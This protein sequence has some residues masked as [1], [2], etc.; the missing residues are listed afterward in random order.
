MPTGYGPSQLQ[1]AY[2]L[3]TPSSVNGS[4]QTVAI[5]DAFDDPTAESD[6]AV[7][8]AQFGLPACTVANGCFSKV[9]QSG[10]A[11]PLPPTAPSD[12]MLE[13]SLDVDMVSAICP[14]CHILLVDAQAPSIE[15]MGAG[16]NA[17]VALGAKF[18]SLSFT[19]NESALDPGYDA[20][21]FHHPGVVIT[22][23]S[24]DS[25]PRSAYPAAS[26]DVTAVGGTTLNPAPNARGW[27]ESAWSS[28]GSIC[29][30]FS[31]KPRW[32]ADTGCRNRSV[33]DV[34][35]I[36]DGPSGVAVYDGGWGGAAG[37]SV[38][39]P[40]IAS[41]YALAG[42]P[43]PGS[44]PAYYPYAH[45]ASLYDVTSGST[46]SSCA[47]T[48]LCTAEAGYDGPTGLGTPNGIAAFAPGLGDMINVVYPGNRT[49]IVGTSG[50]LAIAA[51]DSA[52]LPVTFSA[53]GLPPGMSLNSANGVITGNPTTLGTYY[54]D[55]TATDTAGATGSTMYTWTIVVPGRVVVTNPGSQGGVTGSL[56]TLQVNASVQRTC[57]P[58][59]TYAATSLPAGLTI[60]P[61]NGLISGTPTT[62]AMSI[63]TVVARAS[64]GITGSATFTW[65]IGSP[66]T[67][68]TVRVVNPHDRAATVGT[69]VGI[70]LPA[71][72]SDPTQTLSYELGGDLP[73]GL[74]L[75]PATGLIS[76]VPT[77]AGSF[78]IN[79]GATDSTG[80]LDIAAF[81]LTISANTVTVTSPGNL[82]GT[83]GTAVSV[84]VAATDSDLSEALSY[85]ATGLP[86]G[87]FIN[88]RTGML[89]QGPASAGTYNVTVTATDMT[90]ATGSASFT[91]T[92]SPQ[93]PD[94]VL[95]AFPGNPGGDV[96]GTAM[97]LQLSGTYTLPVTY[98]A[99]G[100]PPGITISPG[101]LLSGTPTTAGSYQVTVTATDPLGTTGSIIL[102]WG[103]G[104]RGGNIIQ[105]PTPGVQGGPVG[106]LVSLPVNASDSDPAQPL[107]FTANLPPGLWINP[108]TGLISGAPAAPGVYTIDVNVTD[109]TAA[110]ADMTFTWTIGAPGIGNTVIVAQPRNQST[111]A[112]SGT[113][114]QVQAGDTDP[115][116]VLG[117]S[118]AGLPAGMSIDPASGLIS[119]PP[120]TSGTYT[121]TVSVSD[122]AAASGSATFTWTVT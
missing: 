90:G 22:A 84:P 2:N 109:T 64:S 100:L 104:V 29:S 81:L 92:V 60:N 87:V 69:E 15:N 46:A 21:F 89:W 106:T 65:T 107:S 28:A 93:P 102:T 8:R 48:Y 79:V 50:G 33:A 74:S 62:V 80:A 73:P 36:A 27:T 121:V 44:N 45:T 38:A 70:P 1:A 32:Q 114:L 94:T 40:V 105:V 5:V 9:N 88:S 19:A 43:A 34:S 52:G 83:V 6:L 20:A 53:T 17:A 96:V 111:H 26:P 59:L 101:G 112:G 77:T 117:Y 99:T 7:Y 12:W 57:C 49:T 75:D 115:S 108:L 76:G 51:G 24:G 42:T 11:S 41:V 113:F 78:N 14:R 103:V 91:W 86:P 119:G 71:G 13:I 10:A 61:A 68:N 98:S 122:T 95:V 116:Q 30:S 66:G 3:A 25:G 67:A 23:A 85:S 63:V 118:A 56:V 55:V 82:S 18:V 97:S 54:V 47:P 16:V 120:A 72:D 31:L 58:T 110:S 39:T 4:G 37:T 35:A